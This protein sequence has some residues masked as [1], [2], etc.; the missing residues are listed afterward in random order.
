V[1]QNDIVFGNVNANRGHYTVAADALRRADRAG[2]TGCSTRRRAARGARAGLRPRAGRRE[3]VLEV[4][5]AAT[6]PCRAS[7]ADAVS[8]TC[9]PS[10]SST[11]GTNYVFVRVTASNAAGT[12]GAADSASVLIGP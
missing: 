12:G 11:R 8:G 7:R 4:A 10:L 3:V 6:A 2:S 5:G 9:R 1:L